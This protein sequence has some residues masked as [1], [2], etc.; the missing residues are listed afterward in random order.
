M[1]TAID[2]VQL[3][4]NV[5]HA[6]QRVDLY[7]PSYWN[8]EATV[9]NEK[10]PH[11]SNLTKKQLSQLPLSKEITVLDV[12]AGTGRMTL[13][14]AKRVKHVTAL[15][16]SERMLAFLSDKARRQQ[17]CNISYI[18][19]TLEDMDVSC[20][21]DLVVASFSLFMFDIKDALLKMNT[22]A[23]KGVYLFLCASPWVDTE[24]Q[25][26]IYDSRS[27]WSDFIFIYN[28]LHDLEI[29]P[30]VQIR[31]YTLKQCFMNL[32]DAVD[33]T[34]QR[35][36]IPIEKKMKLRAYLQATC[37]EEKGKL[38]YNRKRKAATIWWTKNH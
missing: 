23:R 21:Y 13:P 3:R 28:I 7:S 35:Y 38:W 8:K 33:K 5:L 1:A 2:W 37:V 16:P 12:G 19:K 31:I 18:N 9:I 17:I 26:A 36:H 6:T 29:I 22:L 11:W 25:L 30:N 27:Y 20:S 14:I 15:E 32:D 34:L 10:L 24:L 4:K